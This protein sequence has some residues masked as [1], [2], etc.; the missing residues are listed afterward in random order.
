MKKIFS[1]FLLFVLISGQFQIGSVYAE[2]LSA[3]EKEKKTQT[4]VIEKLE[5]KIE[6]S[7]ESFE[8]KAEALQIE[9][10]LE[11]KSEEISEYLQNVQEK[12]EGESS[13]LDIREIVQEAKKVVVL[14]LVSGTT[15]DQD[16]SEALPAEIQNNSAK[17][18]I[19]LETI[20]DSMQTTSGDYS[21]IV[22]TQ[23][24]Q[25]KV[26]KLFHSFDSE[27]R[28]EFLYENNSLS[29][30]EVFLG[31]ESI[32]KQEMMADIS[33]GILPESFLG[34]EVI[35]PEVFTLSETV[36]QSGENLSSTWG[37]EQYKAYNYLSAEDTE[38]TPIKVG[39][40]DT[41][42]DASHPDLV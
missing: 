29:Y 6:G 4:Q 14:K 21:I 33:N 9:E 13:R 24:S 32:F 28:I 7:K 12:I 27:T 19:A 11:K 5:E 34:I 2:N 36:I 30:F 1:L 18:E 23:Y 15:P 38:S 39:V 26:E 37:V 25:E 31:A 8:K 3:L 17:K 20:Q 35:L 40:V 42:I 16:I 10:K 41:G 22:K